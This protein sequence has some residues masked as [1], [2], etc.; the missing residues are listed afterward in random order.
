MEAEAFCAYLYKK[1]YTWYLLQNDSD[2]LAYGC[3][4]IVDFELTKLMKK[5]KLHILIMIIC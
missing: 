3:N 2:I 4:L 5:V 1:R